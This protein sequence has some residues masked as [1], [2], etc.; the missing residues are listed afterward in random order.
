VHFC[1]LEFIFGNEVMILKEV[2]ESKGV[3]GFY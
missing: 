2:K 1:V 3:D